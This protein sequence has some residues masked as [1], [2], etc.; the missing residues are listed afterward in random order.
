MSQSSQAGS[1]P[2]RQRSPSVNTHWPRVPDVRIS[3][4][5]FERRPLP[6]DLF[7]SNRASFSVSLATAS[8]SCFDR[9]KWYSRQNIEVLAGLGARIDRRDWYEASG[10]VQVLDRSPSAPLPLDF[11]G[12]T[13]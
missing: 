5:I 8:E 13:K 4:A 3:M 7:P 2:R 12:P 10:R 9:S 6:E 1:L 11:L